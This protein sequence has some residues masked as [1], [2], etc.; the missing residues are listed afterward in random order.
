[1]VVMACPGSRCHVRL[2]AMIA[3]APRQRAIA[4]AAWPA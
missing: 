4:V 2:P 3:F 1:M